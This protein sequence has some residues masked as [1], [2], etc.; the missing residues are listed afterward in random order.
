M[1]SI[2]VL[3]LS[4]EILF[5]L[6]EHMPYKVFPFLFWYERVWGSVGCHDV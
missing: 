2:E 6:E 4:V 1:S 3:F 5:C